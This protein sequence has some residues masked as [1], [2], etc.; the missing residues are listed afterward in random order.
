MSTTT[1]P[2]RGMFSFWHDLP[3]EGRL[4]LSTVIVDALGIGFALPLLGL[5][6]SLIDRYGPRRFQIA[7]LTMNVLGS[8]VLAFATTPVLAAL[9][10]TLFG[11]GQAV[12]WPA[13][14]SLIA[15]VIPA[16]LRQRY[17]GTSFTVLNLGIGVGGLAAGL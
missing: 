7:A 11:A 3:H 13:S 1:S 8:A 5:I 6:G 9:A 10:Y 4:L 12:F 16:G 17:F 2:S 15:D 14:Q